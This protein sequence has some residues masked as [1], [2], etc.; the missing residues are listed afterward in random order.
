MEDDQ[1]QKEPVSKSQRK[2]EANAA[3]ELGRALLDLAESEWKRMSLPDELVAA[4]TE[5]R[6]L[7]AHGALKRQMQYIGKL[8]RS[9]D[10]A[11]VA[12]RL[13]AIRNENRRAA[14]AHHRLEDL[15]DRLI[16]EGD[17]AVDALLQEHPH[18]DAKQLR[19]LVRQARVERRQGA[20]PRTSRA[21]FR[22]LRDVIDN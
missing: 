22:F 15:R 12:D 8:M 10:T 19:G 3:Q 1:E 7:R 11:P 17:K 5:A 2:R 18:V 16:D 13:D 21:L 14:K 20:S 6:R 9:I 4:L